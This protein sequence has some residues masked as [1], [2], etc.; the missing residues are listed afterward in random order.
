MI[1]ENFFARK[2]PADRKINWNRAAKTGKINE[3]KP[4]RA[5]LI[6]EQRESME[7]A[8]PR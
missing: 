2:H 6:P 7:R 1:D 8:R 3:F 5:L 4:E